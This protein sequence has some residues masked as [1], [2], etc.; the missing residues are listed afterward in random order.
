MIF[1][2]LLFLFRFLPIVLLLYYAVPKKLRNLVLLLVSLVFY[3]WGEPVYVV[4]MIVSILISW[5]GGLAVDHFLRAGNEK[6]AR[7]SLG[8][9]VAAGL[10]LLGFFKYADF[11]LRTI[12]QAAGSDIPL[13]RLALPIGISFYTFQTISYI[14]DVYRGTASVQ[15]NIIS[16][17]AYV[18]MF[19]QLIAGPIVQYKTIDRQL[20]SRHESSEEFADGVMRF[21][22]G[23]GK[24][25]LLANNAGVLWDSIRVMDTGN[26]PVLTAWIGIAA[27]TF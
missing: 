6:G 4:L 22:I 17:G 9:S 23:L 5:S 27:Y 13:L 19:P 2:S 7:I 1:S 26:L 10:S 12:N 18:T 16:Y 8:V 14:I 20:R 21:M 11:V 24:K 15:T 25:V 3:A